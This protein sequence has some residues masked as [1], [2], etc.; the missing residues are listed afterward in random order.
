MS[1]VGEEVRETSYIP[2][3]DGIRAVSIL[4]VFAAHAGVSPLIPGG[5]GV[6]VFFFLSGYLITTLLCREYDRYGAISL[7]AFYA[8]RVLRLTPPLLV[9]LA[10]TAAAAW[11]GLVDGSFEPDVV[12]SQIFF[13]FNYYW[14]YGNHLEG[15]AGLSILWSLSVEEHFYLIWPLLFIAIAR[16]RIGTHHVLA[17]LALILAWRCV[18][19]LVFGAPEWT[20]Y[21]S[22]DT[23]FDSLLYGCLLALMAHNGAA[24]RIFPAGRARW[25]LMAAALAVIFAT[26][27]VRDET[28]RSTL[29]YSLQGI[30]L[31]PLFHYAVTRPQEPVFRPLNWAPVRRIGVYSYTLYLVHLVVIL[32]MEHVGMDIS[33]RLVFV[34]VAAA[35][36]L[37]Y[38][39]AVFEFVERPLAPLRKRIKGH[40][41]QARAPA[42]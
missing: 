17:L 33:N 41:W 10:A 36:S 42:F 22:T 4:I 27:L 28:F 23:R 35:I 1:Q 14:I 30:A 2:S 11:F 29:R 37:A 24:E 19:V 21:I 39:A 16:G 5:F 20:I 13:Y 12:A 7:R 15:Y 25:L 9:T 3:L 18:R 32:A 26:F 40:P 31:M 6:T 38:A 8:R 34:P